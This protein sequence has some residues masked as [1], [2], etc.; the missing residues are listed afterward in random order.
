MGISIKAREKRNWFG[1]S[2]AC[3]STQPIWEHRKPFLDER[4]NVFKRPRTWSTSPTANCPGLC[5]TIAVVARENGGTEKITTLFKWKRRA[6]ALLLLFLRRRGEKLA[7]KC[8][9][10]SPKHVY[11][12]WAEQGI[13][14]CELMGAF[15]SHRPSAAQPRYDLAVSASHLEKKKKMFWKV[16]SLLFM[17]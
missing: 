4:R 5:S 15:S 17:V 14:L 2:Q 8:L 16:F 13:R 6:A 9:L 12:V 10:T 3:N 7:N 1:E 11:V